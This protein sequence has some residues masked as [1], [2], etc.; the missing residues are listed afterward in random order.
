VLIIPV[1]KRMKCQ[2]LEAIDRIKDNQDQRCAEIIHNVINGASRAASAPIDRIDNKVK[3]VTEF[4][5]NNGKVS[6]KQQ[7]KVAS[8]P[9][10]TTTT[11]TNKALVLAQ[12]FRSMR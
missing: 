2:I 9:T 11:T 1:K 4:I 5:V 6:T 7:S 12:F 8:S 3:V 10:V